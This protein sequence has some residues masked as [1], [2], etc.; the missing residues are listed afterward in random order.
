MLYIVGLR[1]RYISTPPSPVPHVLRIGSILGNYCRAGGRP[2]RPMLGILGLREGQYVFLEGLVL[3]PI[4]V[5]AVP[6]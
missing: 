1:G 5:E 4:C 6:W 3:L 2:L